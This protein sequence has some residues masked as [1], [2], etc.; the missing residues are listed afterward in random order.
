MALVRVD[1]PDTANS[2]LLKIRFKR[3]GKLWTPGNVRLLS[4]A[5]SD[6]IEQ[7]DQTIGS[8]LYE[9]PVPA[10]VR[11]F[12]TGKRYSWKKRSAVSSKPTPESP[13][14]FVIECYNPGGRTISLSLTMRPSGIQ[15]P[16]SLS[17]AFRRSLGLPPGMRPG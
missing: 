2:Y 9:L 6:R 17:A 13:N 16:H 4:I 1:C 8:V 7:R 15:T 5:E 12:A 10:P 14:L 3:W 11:N